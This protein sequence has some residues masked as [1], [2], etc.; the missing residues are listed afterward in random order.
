MVCLWQRKDHIA[1]AFVARSAIINHYG[2]IKSSI[3]LYHT[4]KHPFDEE[5]LFIRAQGRYLLRIPVSTRVRAEYEH[6]EPEQPETPIA[7]STLRARFMKLQNFDA[8]LFFLKYRLWRWLFRLLGVA[9]ILIGGAPAALSHPA[10]L[11][12]ALLFANSLN[13]GI[14]LEA[15]SLDLWWNRPIKAEGI[16]VYERYRHNKRKMTSTMTAE[17]KPHLD[18][19]R[20]AHK[21]RSP[22][23]RDSLRGVQN[24]VKCSADVEK[25]AGR[26]QQDVLAEESASMMVPEA[27]G[28]QQ[29]KEGGNALPERSRTPLIVVDSVRSTSP[30][31]KIAIG[32]A[33]D[34]VFGVSS[35]ELRWNPTGEIRLLKALQDANLLPKSLETRTRD[36]KRS[37]SHQSDGI[38]IAPTVPVSMRQVN[39]TV[40]FSLELMSGRFG[41]ALSEGRLLVPRELRYATR[42]V[43]NIFS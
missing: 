42:M 1:M 11:K 28:E 19:R 10:G 7:S 13:K 34:F 17:T 22:S 25:S 14:T 5:N 21:S 33:S 4:L 6:H 12:T 20:R 31:W 35:V 9:I 23:Q 37:A 16:A 41:I 3:Y 30:L 32:G 24:N 38:I 40:R 2:R 29:Q 18:E 39:A 36:R 43:C 15:G 27:M 26:V 8:I